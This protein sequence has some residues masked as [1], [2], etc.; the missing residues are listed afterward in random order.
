MK[1]FT[2][3]MINEH[4]NHS[5]FISSLCVSLVLLEDVD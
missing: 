2:L 3:H 5:M 4:L 1:G